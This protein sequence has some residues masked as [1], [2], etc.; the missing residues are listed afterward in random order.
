M[1]SEVIQLIWKSRPHSTHM[2]KPSPFNPFGK[3]IP[4]QLIWKSRPHS[5][6]PKKPSPFN[7]FEKA[8]PIQLIWESRLHSTHMRK[9]SPFNPYEKAVPI[10]PIWKS[11]PHSTH[12][13]KPSPFNPAEKAVKSPSCVD[14]PAALIIQL[15]WSKLTEICTRR[16]WL[17]IHARAHSNLHSTSLRS[18]R[19]EFP[20]WITGG[21]FLS[22]LH[23]LEFLR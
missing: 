2:R 11:R 17:L 13:K 19:L 20:G 3:A 10:Q 21:G 4:I 22:S 9:P 8:V 14:H 6:Q 12:M 16:A 23:W 1:S 15:R 18:I 5:T 7:S